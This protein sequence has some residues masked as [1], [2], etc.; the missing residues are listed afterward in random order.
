MIFICIITITELIGDALD[1]NMKLCYVAH[2]DTAG[3]G[4][5]IYLQITVE[6]FFA[7]ACCNT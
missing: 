2:N 6:Q 4:S 7:R 1:T 5:L 3:S